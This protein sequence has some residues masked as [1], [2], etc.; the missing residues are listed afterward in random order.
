MIVQLVGARGAGLERSVSRARHRAGRMVAAAG[1][2]DD[3]FGLA[4]KECGGSAR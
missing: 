1:A 4:A 2:D 3:E